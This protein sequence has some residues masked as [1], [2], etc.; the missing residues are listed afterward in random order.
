MPIR[1]TTLK[2][3]LR[4]KELRRAPTPAE[5]KLWLHIRG[6]QLNGH[7]FRRQHAIGP[8]ITDFSCIKAKLVI[9]LD[10]GQHVEQETYDLMRTMYLQS[11]GYRVL[12]FWNDDVLKNIDRVVGV[13]LDDLGP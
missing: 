1:R 11:R 6:N 12:R 4:A 7:S 9:E 10:G 13:I 8:F 3:N 5:A 2:T